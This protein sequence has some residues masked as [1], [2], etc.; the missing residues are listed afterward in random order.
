MAS[1]VRSVEFVSVSVTAS[2]EPVTVN[3][4]KEQ[5]ETQCVPFWSMRN[6]GIITDQHQDRMGEVE[7]VDNSGTPAVRVSASARADNDTTI[8]QVFVVEFIAA[9]TVQQV[10][11][12]GFTGASVNQTIDDV[13]AQANAFLIYSYQY[14]DNPT[15]DDDFDDACVQVRFNGSS[16]TSVTLSRRGTGGTVNGTL[17]VVEAGAGEFVV[18][19]REIDV[20]SSSAASATDTISSTTEAD[21][22]LLH[23]YETSEDSDDMRDGAWQADLQDDVTVRVRRGDTSPS[24]Q[25]ATSTHSIAVVECQNQEWAVIERN[26]NFTLSTTPD[27]DSVSPFEP[28]RSIVNCLDHSG[29]PYSVGR[30]DSIQGNDIDNTMS[31]ADFVGIDFVRYTKLDTTLTTDIVSFE[32]VQFVVPTAERGTLRGVLRGVGRGI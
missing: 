3:L 21:T 30:N 6:T 29:H 28:S 10:D 9:I 22:F 14:T 16:T 31:A 15:S 26:A 4:S 18:D 19:H 17:F 11:V 20:T 1:I 12:S 23:S 25:N 24:G 7:I 2:A 8:F 32:V 13:T 5:D 27:A